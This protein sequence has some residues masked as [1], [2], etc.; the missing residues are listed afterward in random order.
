MA[1]EVELVVAGKGISAARGAKAAGGE[2]VAMGFVGS[3]E[4]SLYARDLGEEG[5]ATALIPFPGPTRTHTTLLD[6]NSHSVT[7]IRERGPTISPAI[8]EGLIAILNDQL[9]K[10]DVLVLCGS[11]P[12]GLPDDSFAQLVRLGKS[13]GCLTLLDT[14]RQPLRLGLE[15]KPYMIKPNTAELEEICGVELGRE[16]DLIKAAT[17]LNRNGIEL[18]VVSRGEEGVIV[19]YKGGVWSGAVEL[20][21]IVNTVGCGDALVGGMATALAEGSPIEE[22]IKKGVACAAANAIT[23]ASGYCRRE[24]IEIFYS[25]VQLKKLIE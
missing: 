3:E 1:Q 5:L 19:T 24:D 9:K 16:E 12:A 6:P 2:V 7:H 10:G 15:E 25:K 17:D 14:S 23:V 11:L 13:N 18:V 4:L 8:L 22:I 20:D 21:R